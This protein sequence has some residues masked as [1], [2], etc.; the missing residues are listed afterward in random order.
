MSFPLLIRHHDRDRTRHTDD[1]SGR[2]ERRKSQGGQT[3]TY[4]AIIVEAQKLWIRGRFTISIILN[5]LKAVAI[6]S[7]AKVMIVREMRIRQQLLQNAAERAQEMENVHWY[8][9]REI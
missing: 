2:S 5:V 8:K 7:R 1:K 3:R 4:A 9:D 6:H